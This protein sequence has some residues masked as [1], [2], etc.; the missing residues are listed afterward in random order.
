MHWKLWGRKKRNR[1]L[2]EEI[3]FDLA[4]EAEDRAAGGVSA[5]AAWA[6]SRKDFGNVLLVEEATREMWGLTFLE[7]LAQDV[8][9][10][11]RMLGRSGGLTAIAVVSLA[12]GIGANTAMYSFMDALL[13]RSL[14]VPDP[15]SLVAIQWHTRGRE[16]PKVIHGFMIGGHAE[17]KTGFTSGSLPYQAYEALSDRPVLRSTFALTPGGQRNIQIGGQAELGQAD[18]VSGTFFSGL[19]MTPA[20]GRLLDAADD[21]PGAPPAAVLS[22]SYAQRRFGDI[23]RAAG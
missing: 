13:V 1:D 2:E 18:F 17:E 20:A 6:E 11:L 16:Q 8:K 7:R 9:Y 19:E 3:A 10:G 4:A 23:A 12:L 21:R 14:P 22:F 15:Q 5:E